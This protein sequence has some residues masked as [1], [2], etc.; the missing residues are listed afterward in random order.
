MAT[1]CKGV[2]RRR[3]QS[4]RSTAAALHIY[5]RSMQIHPRDVP[6]R[7]QHPSITATGRQ[8]SSAAATAD[9]RSCGPVARRGT[10]ERLPP[11]CSPLAQSVRAPCARRRTC[12]ASYASPPVSAAPATQFRNRIT[13]LADYKIVRLRVIAEL[14]PFVAR[15]LHRF[16][17]TPLFLRHLC[18]CLHR[19]RLRQNVAAA[20]RAIAQRGRTWILNRL[21][22]E[23]TIV[24]RLNK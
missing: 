17:R 11:P 19:H 10:Q 9:T 3:A 8:A 12:R 2:R 18:C 15:A 4:S 16:H 20:S 21:P 14:H 23:R 22:P 1:A 24:W 13:E 6:I 5:R 7:T